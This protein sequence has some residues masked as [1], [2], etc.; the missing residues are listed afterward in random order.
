MLAPPAPFGGGA[1][2]PPGRRAFVLFDGV[3]Y[4]ALSRPA[5]DG[6]PDELDERVFA[7]AQYAALTAGAGLPWLLFDADEQQL[8]RLGGVG[9]RHRRRRPW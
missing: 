3:H 1:V 5:A 8:P 7:P 6:A 9:Q 4:D 2:S